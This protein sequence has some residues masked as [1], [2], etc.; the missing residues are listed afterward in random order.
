[1]IRRVKPE[2][3]A[4]LTEVIRA[5][6]APYQDAGL[7]LPPVDEGIAE[8]IRDRMVFVAETDGRITGGVVMTATPP[9]AHLLNLAVDPE[10]GGQGL[11]TAL[12]AR[13]VTEAR[14]A[15]CRVM[16]LTTHREMTNTQAFYR[17][18]GWQDD[19]AEG[20]KVFLRLAF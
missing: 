19:G 8:D 9:A 11:G 2:D 13:A 6:Y 7:D 10:A 5:A 17:R 4:A 20:D 14:M 16:R 18:L 1:M 3:E 12:L 15:G